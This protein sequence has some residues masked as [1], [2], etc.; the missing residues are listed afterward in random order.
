MAR[1]HEYIL[2]VVDYA[3]RYPEGVRLQKATP[4]NIAREIFM[5]FSRVG[6]P[7]EIL[8]DQCT[9]FSLLSPDGRPGRAL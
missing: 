9:P 3:T 7:A 4:K 2:V 8:T 1:G 5:L 6:I